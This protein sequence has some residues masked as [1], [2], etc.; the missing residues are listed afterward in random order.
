M[1]YKCIQRGTVLL[2]MIFTLLLFVFT[3]VFAA[4]AQLP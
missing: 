2:S 4:L 3:G 1:N